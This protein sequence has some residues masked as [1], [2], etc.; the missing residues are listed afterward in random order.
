L[1]LAQLRQLS[2]FKASLAFYGQVEEQLSR[3]E[4]VVQQQKLVSVAVMV[5]FLLALREVLR[6]LASLLVSLKPQ[7]ALQVVL[8]LQAT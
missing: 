3:L 1:N 4:L 6:L 8:R 7:S 2:G 5:G